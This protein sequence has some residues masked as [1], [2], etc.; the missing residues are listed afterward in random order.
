MISGMKTYSITLPCCVIGKHI[1]MDQ[2]HRI[3]FF[4]IGVYSIFR[5]EQ[6]LFVTNINTRSVLVPVELTF[7][8]YERYEGIIAKMKLSL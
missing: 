4:N 6:K 3:I 8:A 5:G 1:Y 7:N 2:K